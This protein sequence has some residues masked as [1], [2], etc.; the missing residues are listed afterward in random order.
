[1]GFHHN[2]G[3]GNGTRQMQYIS[4]FKYSFVLLLYAIN[5]AQTCMC[6][7]ID[8]IAMLRSQLLVRLST[9]SNSTFDIQKQDD[10]SISPSSKKSKSSF[11]NLRLQVKLP[12]KPSPPLI[13]PVTPR[14][15]DNATGA[16]VGRTRTALIYAPTVLV[17]F[18]AG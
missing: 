2:S 6:L 11:H 14:V 1:M 10:G 17:S 3:T 5:T 15:H 4:S 16:S 9:L 7:P 18:H 8:A 12:P 13:S